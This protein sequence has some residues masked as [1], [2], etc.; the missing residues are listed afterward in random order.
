MTRLIR[1]AFLVMCALLALNCVALPNGAQAAGRGETVAHTL[2]IRTHQPGMHRLTYDDLVNAGVP[3][4][5]DTAT[6]AMRYEDSPIDIQVLGSAGT[7]TPDDIVVFFA[8]SFRSRY[9]ND[10]VYFFSYGGPISAERIASRP[11]A[12]PARS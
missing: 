8:Q 11:A 6:F 12:A 10:N 1:R 3:A 9:T 2:R 7:L 4:D 5:A